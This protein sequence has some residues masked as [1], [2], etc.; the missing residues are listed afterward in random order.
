MS[1]IR[2][3][4][5]PQTLPFAPCH[6]LESAR[7]VVYRKRRVENCAMVAY[8]RSCSHLPDG[9]GST[10]IHQSLIHA[11]RFRPCACSSLIAIRHS[12][13]SRQVDQRNELCSAAS[14]T[15]WAAGD[16]RTTDAKTVF[17]CM[18]RSADGVSRN[19]DA[20]KYNN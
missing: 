2:R 4:S 16:Q 12:M 7:D 19:V 20:G 13:T 8:T 14:M 3:L 15:S 5:Q 10:I 6:F 18:M 9:L 17:A 1:I 11:K